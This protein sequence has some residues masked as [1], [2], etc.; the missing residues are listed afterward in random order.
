MP[1]GNN[2]NP[3]QQRT[4]NPKQQEILNHNQTKNFKS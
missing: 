3:N 1:N 2:L 4:L